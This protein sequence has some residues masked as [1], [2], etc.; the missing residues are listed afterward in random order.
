[1]NNTPYEATPEEIAIFLQGMK[2]PSSPVNT[3][4]A[5]MAFLGM[6][7]HDYMTHDWMAHEFTWRESIKII[8]DGFG[9]DIAAT[10]KKR[11]KETYQ[12]RGYNPKR[13]KHAA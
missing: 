11:I 7:R 6:C 5:A 10:I 13:K 1:M 4:Y 8:R 9:E 2:S 12:Q 3:K